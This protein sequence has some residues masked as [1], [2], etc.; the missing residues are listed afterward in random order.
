MAP[1]VRTRQA[2][3]GAV[4]DRGEPYWTVLSFADD[5]AEFWVFAVIAGVFIV[6]AVVLAWQVL[7]TF[8][9]DRHER[10]ARRAEQRARDRAYAEKLKERK[11]A[12]RESNREGTA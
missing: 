7:P 2:E 6:G 9:E 1:T 5:A 8:W 10:R 3:G 11:R 4:I 12:L